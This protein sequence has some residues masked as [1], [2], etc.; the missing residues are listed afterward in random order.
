MRLAPSKFKFVSKNLPVFL[1]LILGFVLFLPFPKSIR[2]ASCTDGPTRA[3]GLVTSPTLSGSFGTSSGACVIDPKS[4]PF[5]PF[6]IPT[7][8]DLKS[9]YYD[10]ANTLL[11]D[12]HPA[13][14]GDK[15]QNDIP[16]TGSTNNLYYLTGNLNITS[17]ISGDQTGVVFVNGNLNIGPMSSNKLN[18]GNSNS[19]L[20]FVVRGDIIIDP[21]VTQIDAVI[22]SS[23]TIYTAGAGCFTNAVPSN[24]SLTVNGSLIALSDQ[25]QIKFCRKVPSMAG[26][27]INH[28]PKYLVILRNI[29]SDTLQRWSEVP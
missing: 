10:Q 4:A 13:L 5:L 22:I 15:T 20:V 8:E 28:Q 17:N 19:G 1:V 9:L 3:T 23:G 18:F 21:S 12:K 29:F 2:G 25:T 14:T 24:N 26:E 7:Y 16:M 6:K 11:V 27:L